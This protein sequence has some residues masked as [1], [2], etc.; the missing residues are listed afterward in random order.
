M[1]PRMAKVMVGSKIIFKIR[2]LAQRC[3]IVAKPD[4]HLFAK[5]SR[6]DGLAAPRGG[7]NKN[8]KNKNKTNPIHR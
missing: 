1:R 6:T 8:H 3:D 7:E 4:A 5:A 2:V